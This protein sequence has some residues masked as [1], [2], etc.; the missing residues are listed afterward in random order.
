LNPD[1]NDILFADWNKTTNEIK[2]IYITEFPGGYT[3][4]TYEAN[5]DITNIV[6]NEI[7][8][9]RLNPDVKTMPNQLLGVEELVVNRKLLILRMGFHI[10]TYMNR[11]F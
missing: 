6:R 4:V 7:N 11:R 5:I 9:W 10:Y 3:R 2:L 1:E 8:G